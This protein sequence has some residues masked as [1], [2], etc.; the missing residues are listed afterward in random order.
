[1]NEFLHNNGKIDSGYKVPDGY[2][3]DLQ[4][5]VFA[6]INILETEPKVRSIFSKTTLMWLVAASIVLCFSIFRSLDS[7]P[8][9]NEMDSE[10]L[11]SYIETRPLIDEDLLT[12]LLAE[13][14]ID[15][16]KVAFDVNDN[17]IESELANNPNFEQYIITQ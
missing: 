11:F 8:T 3:D 6:R 1:M 2:F 17:Q 14:N 9:L 4:E 15:P 10:T 7:T 16:A 13:E 5:N 12:G